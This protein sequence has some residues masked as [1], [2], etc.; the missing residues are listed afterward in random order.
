MFNKIQKLRVEELFE[1]F[2][3]NSASLDVILCRDSEL[4][5]EAQNLLEDERKFVLVSLEDEDLYNQRSIL[6]G[7]YHVFFG[8]LPLENEEVVEIIEAIEDNL[9]E[10]QYCLLI[11]DSFSSCIPA[12]Q[13]ALLELV[14]VSRAFKLLVQIDEDFKFS[15]NVHLWNVLAPRS[16]FLEQDN[17]FNN[18]DEDSEQ[19]EE[20]DEFEETEEFEEFDETE[21]LNASDEFDQ[22]FNEVIAPQKK[23]AKDLA[24]YQLIPKYHLAAAL[25]LLVLVFGLWNMDVGQ[26]KEQI[27][28]LDL[29]A[30]QA[31]SETL[32]ETKTQ[33]ILNTSASE[34]DN[35]IIETD[36]GVNEIAQVQTNDTINQEVDSLLPED[37]QKE[38]V[39]SGQ[40][41]EKISNQV[42]QNTTKIENQK[43][44]EKTSEKL[45]AQSAP[46]TKAVQVSKK[47]E[48]PKVNWN[49]YQSDSWIKGLNSKYYTLQLMASHDDQGIRHFLQERG[50]SSEYAVYTSEKNAK[51]WH[52]IIYGVYE[53]RDFADLARK[54]LPNYLKDYSPWVRNIGEVQ[55]S[56]K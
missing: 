12:T 48:A 3:H 16:S 37:T 14:I 42:K 15:E 22:E 26:K 8:E 44:Q 34:A 47:I 39:L 6:E 33:T 46:P 17:H 54:D 24:W 32:D 23:Q 10:G 4:L 2:E 7:L 29:A 11:V 35:A 1:E 55:R 51:P 28:D 5:S 50:V 20:F 27:L 13:A 9:E 49:P 18:D 52:V 45:M 56:L 19:F 31:E 41:V 53:T 43:P 36:S 38:V 40:R 30:E 21:R 25:V